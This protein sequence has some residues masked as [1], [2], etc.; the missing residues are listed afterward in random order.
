M[1]KPAG[2]SWVTL[3]EEASC[4]RCSACHE[5]LHM[6]L[7]EAVHSIGGHEARPDDS[8]ATHCQAPWAPSLEPRA[9]RKRLPPFKIRRKGNHVS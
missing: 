5:S 3:E 7:G 2:L 4:A 1:E 6:C 9:P 8:R